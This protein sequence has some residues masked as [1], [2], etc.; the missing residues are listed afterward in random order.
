MSTT[1]YVF[2]EKYERYRHF[3]DEKKRLICC[4]DPSHYC[5]YCLHNLDSL[6]SLF[7]VLI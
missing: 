6:F 4:Y 3:S 5:H 1:A 2:T 7:E